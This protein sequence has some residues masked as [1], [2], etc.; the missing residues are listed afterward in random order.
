MLKGLGILAYFIIALI[1][2]QV[3]PYSG[4]VGPIGWLCNIMNI[5]VII[6]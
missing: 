4:I 2:I 1:K 5:I 3:T 6:M